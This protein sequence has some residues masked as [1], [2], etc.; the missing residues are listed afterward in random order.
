[1]ATWLKESNHDKANKVILFLISPFLAFVYSLK[2]IKTKSSY[3]V[4]FL[5]SIFFGMAFSVQSGK[6]GDVTI[7]GAAYR[8]RFDIYKLVSHREF[9]ENFKDFLTFSEERKIII[10]TQLLLCFQDNG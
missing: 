4:F 9:T 1:M 3:V 6:R 5:F 8:E 7:D 10:L 2:R